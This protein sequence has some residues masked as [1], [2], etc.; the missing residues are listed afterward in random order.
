M[1]DLQRHLTTDFRHA[2]RLAKKEADREKLAAE[3][4]LLFNNK[5]VGNKVTNTS[6]ALNKS[7]TIVTPGKRK[8]TFLEKNDENCASAANK[9]TAKAPVDGKTPL[10]SKKQRKG[11]LVLSPKPQAHQLAGLSKT[12]PAI[13]TYRAHA[14]SPAPPT[15]ATVSKEAAVA[16]E[17]GVQLLELPKKSLFADAELEKSTSARN[18]LGSAGETLILTDTPMLVDQVTLPPC[19]TLI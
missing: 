16:T 19:A 8:S 13:P 15:P 11:S 17:A 9:I 10:S 14:E 3:F 12:L 1:V 7:A 2:S 5:T 6:L 18:S 4:P